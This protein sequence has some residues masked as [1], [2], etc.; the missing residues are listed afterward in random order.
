MTA[1]T[2][3]SGSGK[4]SLVLETLVPLVRTVLSTR[5]PVSQLQGAESITRL[6]VVDQSPL[7]RSGRSNPAT[8]SGVW[9]AFRRVFARTKDARLR[10][11]GPRRF[12]FNDASGRC[13]VCRGTGTRRLSAASLAGLEMPCPECRGAR[14]NRQTLQVRFKGMN[15]A[16][17]LALRID[18]A[19]ERFSPI[20]PIRRT[21]AMFVEISLGYLTLGQPAPTLSGGEAQRIKLAAELGQTDELTAGKTLYVLDEPTTGLHPADVQRL[22]TLLTRLAEA[23]HTVVVI[24]HHLDVIAA[25][26]WI[27]DLGPEAGEAGGRVVAEG[28]PATVAGCESSHTGR[29][30][31]RTLLRDAGGSY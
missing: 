26:D 23:G 10:G 11:F 19:L 30:L 16:D 22:L 24:E 5:A 4:T 21:L 31:G 28:P 12:S 7:G 27:I 8:A 9:D 13:P 25:A 20:E 15:V 17:V 6:I 3:V 1:V 18:E 29:A 14:F 2:G